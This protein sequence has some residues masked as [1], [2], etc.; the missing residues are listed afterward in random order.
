MDTFGYP[1]FFISQPYPKI[2]LY[3]HPHS[4]AQIA[5]LIYIAYSFPRAEL[6]CSNGLP[7]AFN[8]LQARCLDAARLHSFALVCSSFANIRLIHSYLRHFWRLQTSF[9]NF[10]KLNFA[11]PFT[12]LRVSKRFLHPWQQYQI[13]F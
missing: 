4:L 3:S 1:S 11:T 13:L 9:C 6:F 10:F 2:M 5:S 8:P 7:F 12:F